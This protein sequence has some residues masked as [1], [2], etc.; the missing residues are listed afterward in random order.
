VHRLPRGQIE[1]GSLPLAAGQES[2]PSHCAQAW[3]LL[4]HPVALP[5]LP[6]CQ[7][8]FPV[9]P[10]LMRSPPWAVIGRGRLLEPCAA[11]YWTTAECQARLSPPAWMSLQQPL[12]AAQTLQRSLA[13]GRPSLPAPKAAPGTE[14]RLCSPD[15]GPHLLLKPLWL[16]ANV[17][18]DALWSLLAKHCCAGG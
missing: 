3:T 6:F 15:Y 16:G 10:Q 17:N 13:L 18:Q 4:C 11:S 5:D 8:W 14:T 2:P 9:L 12:P 1:G 7:S